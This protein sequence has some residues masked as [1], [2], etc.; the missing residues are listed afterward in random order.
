M[1]SS[2]DTEVMSV[3]DWMLTI[4]VLAIPFVNL[5]MYLVWAFGSA[6]NLNRKNFCK[7]SLLWFV[8]IFGIA[9]VIGILSAIFG[10]GMS[11]LQPPTPTP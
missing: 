7:A 2:H 9:I 8:I 10:A 11:Q 3:K 6:G 4:L 1:D 5:I